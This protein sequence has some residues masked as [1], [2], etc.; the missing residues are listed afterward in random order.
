[1]EEKR[2]NFDIVFRKLEEVKEE[3][4]QIINSDF[5][6]SKEIQE[7]IRELKEYYDDSSQELDTYTR[8]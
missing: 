2:Y 6:I 3:Q 8:S 5:I 1:M 7:Q 4:G